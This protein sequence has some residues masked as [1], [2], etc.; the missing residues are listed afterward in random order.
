MDKKIGNYSFIAGVILAIVLAIPVAIV[1]SMRVW[2]TALL[3]LAG[4]IVGLLNVSGKETKDFLIAAIVLVI[5]AGIGNAATTLEQVAGTIPLIGKLI[6]ELF[7]NIVVF[8]VP[9]TVV[10]ALKALQT[11]ANKA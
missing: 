6:A 2:L 3:V 10:V 7:K 5:A 1:D 11:M 9:A 8:A 4:I